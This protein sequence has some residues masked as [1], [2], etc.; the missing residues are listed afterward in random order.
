M[1]KHACL[2]R[3]VDTEHHWPLTRDRPC[4]QG[5]LQACERCSSMLGR[6]S[7]SRREGLAH[8][9]LCTSIRGRSYPEAKG[10]ISER[11]NRNYSGLTLP[12]LFGSLSLSVKSL[13]PQILFDNIKSTPKRQLI[14]IPGGDALTG[15]VLLVDPIS[16]HPSSP[17]F[18]IRTFAFGSYSTST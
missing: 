7:S 18:Y 17:R 8:L 16:V 5:Q 14:Q 2:D 13:Q 1:W 11:G 10:D 15:L 9:A 12:Y 4:S 3:L 6:Y